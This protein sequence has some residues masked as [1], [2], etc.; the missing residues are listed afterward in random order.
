MES[1]Y[2]NKIYKYSIRDTTEPLGDGS[3]N[4]SSG[5]SGNYSTAQLT[6]HNATGIVITANGPCIYSISLGTP[7]LAPSTFVS[8]GETKTIT[9]L[10]YKGCCAFGIMPYNTYSELDYTYEGDVYQQTLESVGGRYHI[11]TGDATII[12][13]GGGR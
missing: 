6:I 7:L 5:G 12:V 3:E 1:S 2:N 10:L 4:S 11:I 8:P 13:S 9:V